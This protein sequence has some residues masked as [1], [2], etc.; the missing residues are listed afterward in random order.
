MIDN[1]A[2][3]FYSGGF[4]Y[5]PKTN[6]IFLHIRDGNTKLNPNK[7]AF[8]G[9]LNEGNEMPYQCFKRELNEEIG[10]D[11]AL[12][13][14]IYLDEYLNKEVNVYR[15]IFYVESDIDKKEL[16][17]GEGADFDWFSFEVI[18]SQYITEKARKDLTNF[19]SKRIK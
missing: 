17:L 16:K 3:K 19:I 18:E 6:K 7:I 15:Y 9:G 5:N 1:H 8:F 11:V 10:L 14:I 2:K 13:Q 12:S 4:L